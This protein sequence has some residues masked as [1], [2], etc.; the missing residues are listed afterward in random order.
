MIFSNESL[1]KLEE[2]VGRRLSEKRFI[3]TGGVVK[4]AIYIASFLG[5][6]DESELR[7][8]ALLHDI[9]KEIPT[10]ESMSILKSAT[11]PASDA[12]LLCPPAHHAFVAPEIIK[13]DFPTFATDAVISSVRNHTTADPDMTDFDMVI[14]ISDYIEEGRTYKDCVTLRDKLYLRLSA[15]RDGDEARAH[16]YDAVI[17]CLDNTIRFVLARGIFLHEKTVAARNRL[18]AKR[19]VLL[20]TEEK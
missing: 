14:F 18:L 5:G 11:P 6:L 13:R 15:S 19:P 7:A 8:A 16:L 12:D 9:A 20:K 4:S 3:H 17:E 1:E 2:E 10:E